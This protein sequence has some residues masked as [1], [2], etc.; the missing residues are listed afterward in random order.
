MCV[1]R[2]G[3]TQR[4]EVVAGRSERRDCLD[5]SWFPT[6]A[7]ADLLPVPLPNLLAD[8]A[9][10]L[11]EYRLDGIILTGGNDL[12][13]V[14]N[15]DC[16]APE[17]DRFER[18][19]LELCTVRNLP[20]L[21]V[22]RGM[23]HLV[24]FHGGTITRVSG[25]V[26]STHRIIGTGLTDLAIDEGRVVNSFHGYGVHGVGIP[27]CLAIAAVAEDETVEAVS[28]RSLPQWGIMWHPERAPVSMMDTRLL[29]ALFHCP[30]L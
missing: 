24:S 15:A 11:D 12:A 30:G 6:L 21:G 9:I 16:T 8:P 14:E 18:G 1:K 26:S 28:H 22:C 13:F 19:L 25:H 29:T 4:V 27:A 2:I 17:R 5:Q 10:A 20:V 7:S 23:Q 3:L